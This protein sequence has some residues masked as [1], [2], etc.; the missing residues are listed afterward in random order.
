MIKIYN[1]G[2]RITAAINGDID[3]HS[4]REYRTILND[5]IEHS[6]PELLVID[7]ENVGI[8][9]SSGVGLILGRLRTVRSVGG[10]LQVKN[11]KPEIADVFRLAGL[12]SLI[13]E[14]KSDCSKRSF[15]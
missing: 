3:Q 4:A 5:V 1:D 13:V 2:K 7:M 12:S 10:E 6:R 15:V 11:A 9:D 14:T 8:M